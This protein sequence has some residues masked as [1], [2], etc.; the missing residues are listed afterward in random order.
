[1][2]GYSNEMKQL[3]ESNPGLK[4]RF[5]KFIEFKDYSP[6]ELV[7][8][9][10]LYGEQFDFHLTNEAQNWIISYLNEKPVEGNGRFATNLIN[11]AI[12]AQAQRL[13]IGKKNITQREAMIIEKV[14]IEIALN[15]ALF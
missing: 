4:S 3:L 15:K 6:I 5:K 7:Q 2:A 1:M 11:E 9:M 14:D 13:M 12:Q 8:I 10:K